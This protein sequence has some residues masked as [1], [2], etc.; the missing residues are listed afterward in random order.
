[1]LTQITEVNGRNEAIFDIYAI[2]GYGLK[3]IG[4]ISDRYS[5]VSLMVKQQPLAR[6]KS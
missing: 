6:N 3:E 5:R 2:G 4:D 1:M